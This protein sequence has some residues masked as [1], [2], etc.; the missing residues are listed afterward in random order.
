MKFSVRVVSSLCCFL[1]LCSAN[2]VAQNGPLPF[3]TAIELALKNSAITGIARADAQ[4]AQ[5]NYLQA[6]NLFLPQVTLGAGLAYSNGF[7]LSL[8]GAAP[9]IF[10]VNT[11]S[12]L[13]NPAQRQ[14]M[15]AAKGDV[16][17]TQAQNADRRNDVMMETAIA[18]IQL[19]LLQSSLN[20]Q[21]EQQEFAAKFEDI[22]GQR[23]QAGLDASVELTRAKL[24][25]ART[26]M[27][28]ADIQSA[29]D[30]L[31]LRLSQLTGLPVSAIQT[32]TETIPKLPDVAQDTDLAAQAVQKN[33][34]VQIAEQAAKARAFK[35]K[36]EA[37]QLYPALDLVAQYAV[38]A[39]YN[40]YDEFFRKFQRHNVTV[41]AVIRFPFLNP[42]QREV[43]KA[44]E[45]DALKAQ[46]EAQNVKDQVS[47]ETLRLQR[48]VQ[49]LSAA[50][51]V[52][53]LEHQL[54]Q[55]DIETTHEKIQA[56]QASLK[57]EQNARITEHQHYSA[58][59]N[60]SFELDKAQVQLLRQIG[61]LEDWALGPA[62][63]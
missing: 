63:R 59:L 6:R 16:S 24:T 44:A 21:K 30:Q 45:A 29:V 57:D 25:S 51:E 1:F 7:P 48:S 54:A 56:G 22:V 5:A 42:P 28:V 46:K 53:R 43:A 38:L 27:Q 39:R 2:L 50:Q 3:R 20:V 19:D 41:G 13:F 62:K 36:G 47:S 60:S 23:V 9:S 58:F 32:S 61:E 35:A 37:K 17:T 18:Y 15:K 4:R 8:E 12:F 40:N 26:R 34:A 52:F 49:Q 10:N 14:F 11:Q 55:S 33:P 31:R